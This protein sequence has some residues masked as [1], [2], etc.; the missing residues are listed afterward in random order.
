M[1]LLTFSAAICIVLLV[2]SVCVPCSAACRRWGLLGY[3]PLRQ[4]KVLITVGQLLKG[5]K[6]KVQRIYPRGFC[7][8]EA[9]KCGNYFSIEQGVLCRT[10]CG[11]LELG[12]VV[13]DD[14]KRT[15]SSIPIHVP[16]LP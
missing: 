11:T 8:T 7:D 4:D 9:Y 12:D 3:V 6:K 16:V 5:G 10:G 13:E 2:S 15:S 1:T 14:I